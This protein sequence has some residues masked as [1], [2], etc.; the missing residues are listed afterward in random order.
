MKKCQ[1]KVLLVLA[2]FNSDSLKCLILSSTNRYSQTLETEHRGKT[3]RT[4]EG[5]RK[6]TTIAS[7]R[8]VRMRTN[9]TDVLISH[10]TLVPRGLQPVLTPISIPN[11]TLI[12]FPLVHAGELKASGRKYLV[13]ALGVSDAFLAVSP[14][15]HREHNVSHVPIFILEFLKDLRM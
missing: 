13:V 6:T 8:G 1:S 5:R 14:V 4:K 12:T 15:G 10:F 11:D 3:K 9:R 2:R 7:S